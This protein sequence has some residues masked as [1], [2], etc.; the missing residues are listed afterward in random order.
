[1]KLFT[2]VF[3][4]VGGFIVACSYE[5]TIASS[6]LLKKEMNE[7]SAVQNS[8]VLPELKNPRIVV[9]KAKRALEVFDGDKLIKTYR[10]ALGFAPTGDKEK[11]GDGKTPE[12]EFYIFTKNNQSKFYLSLGVSYP[13]SEDAKRGLDAKIITKNQYDQIVKAQNAKKAP[14]QNTRL[15]GEIYIHG[16][17]AS[18]EDWTWGC[19]ALDNK[20]VKELFDRIPVGTMVK[21]EP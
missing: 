21:I 14:P 13:N 7:N 20:N 6:D 17:G 19:V 10:M 5:K 2:I 8:D 12:G 4:I 9:K 1:M 18:G 15:G 3:L 11:Q 16:G